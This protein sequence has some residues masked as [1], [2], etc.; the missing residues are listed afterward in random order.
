MENVNQNARVAFHKRL[1]MM[2]R[3]VLMFQA[4]S[5]Q[6]VAARMPTSL[7]SQGNA[8]YTSLLE[9]IDIKKPILDPI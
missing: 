5:I 1:Q 9:S 3:R 4:E 7:D 6:L 8:I 2:D